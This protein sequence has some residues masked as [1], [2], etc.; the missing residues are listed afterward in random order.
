M[1]LDKAYNSIELERLLD[2]KCSTNLNHT[3]TEI[4]TLNNPIKG[5]LGFLTKAGDYN[6]KLFKG[7]IV[8]DTYSLSLIHI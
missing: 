1:N 6:L 5:S 2:A 8:H 4:S 3:F 7:L